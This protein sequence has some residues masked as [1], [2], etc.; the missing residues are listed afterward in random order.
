ML[1]SLPTQSVV[2]ESEYDVDIRKDYPIMHKFFVMSVV[3]LQEER[4]PD[5]MSIVR[6]SLD[7][8]VPYYSRRKAKR[9]FAGQVSRL[10]KLISLIIR[11]P[12]TGMKYLLDLEGYLHK[13]ALRVTWPL[14]GNTTVLNAAI[15]PSDMT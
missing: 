1:H 12:T 11:Q 8:H 14:F 2:G 4:R 13:L 15:M 7:I 6:F 5:P 10:N 3:L 9:K